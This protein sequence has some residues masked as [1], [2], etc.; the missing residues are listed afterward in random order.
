MCLVWLA[1]LVVAGQSPLRF[2]EPFEKPTPG[3]SLMDGKIGKAA[4]L[5][6]TGIRVATA[7]HL[8]KRQGTICLWIRPQWDGGQQVNH[9]FAADEIDFNRIGDNN[10]YLWHWSVGS[11]RF[12]VRDPKD[13]YV[14]T[15]I[16]WELPTH[17]KGF[18]VGPSHMAGRAAFEPLTYALRTRNPYGIIFYNWHRATTGIDL[19]LRDFARAY[20]GLPA[21]EPRPFD[22]SC[23]PEPD[24][25]LWIRWFDDRLAVVNDSPQPRTIELA[26]PNRDGNQVFDLAACRTVGR[27]QQPT[28]PLCCKV[29]L[30]AYDLR[31]L[32]VR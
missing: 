32:V 16:Y 10:L 1:A 26:I 13:S 25:R 2:H 24:Q 23:A 8:D 19:E 20:R 17:P 4:T 22:G 12:D 31:T 28:G 30:R 15:Y 6:E 5:P 11:L 14:T 7:G 3:L 27:R 29:H 18:A 9:G 21:V